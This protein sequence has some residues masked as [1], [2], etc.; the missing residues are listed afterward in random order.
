MLYVY[1]RKGVEVRSQLLQEIESR[2]EQI[3][4]ERYEILYERMELYDVTNN[5]VQ[6]GMSVQVWTP[7]EKMLTAFLDQQTLSASG[8]EYLFLAGPP[9]TT[10]VNA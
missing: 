10:S 6:V 9:S 4:R 5:R 1:D 2:I 3:S 8:P 7:L